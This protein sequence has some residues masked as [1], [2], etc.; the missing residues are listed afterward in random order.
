MGK[1]IVVVLNAILYNRGSEAL[2][3]GLI[4]I[5]KQADSTCS[6][7]LASNDKG[8]KKGQICHRWTNISAV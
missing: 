8:F 4:Q 5:C 7:T 1:N 2:A 3:R 6:I